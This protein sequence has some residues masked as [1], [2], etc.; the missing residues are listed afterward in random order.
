MSGHSPA[1]SAFDLGS[2]GQLVEV[3]GLLG[4][5]DKALGLE[6]FVLKALQTIAEV[7]DIGHSRIAAG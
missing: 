1:Q 4:C 2:K 3:I 5:G 6:G 7:G